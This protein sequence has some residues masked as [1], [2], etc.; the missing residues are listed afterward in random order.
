MPFFALRIAALLLGA[1]F[2][3]PA[4]GPWYHDAHNGIHETLDVALEDICDRLFLAPTH[5]LRKHQA[6]ALARHTLLAERAALNTAMAADDR[7]ADQLPYPTIADATHPRSITVRL[8]PA[9]PRQAWAQLLTRTRHRL[10][11][12]QRRRIHN[13]IALH[14]R[15]ATTAIP[16]S[17]MSA[18]TRAVDALE[19]AGRPWPLAPEIPAK[20]PLP[21]AEAMRTLTDRLHA[22]GP[23]ADLAGCTLAVEHLRRHAFDRAEHAL[24]LVA[25]L[26]PREGSRDELAYLRAC[27]PLR[28]RLRAGHTGQDAAI[29]DGFANYLADHPDGAWRA[30]ALGWQAFLHHRAYRRSGNTQPAELDAAIA[31]YQRIVQAPDLHDLYIRGVESLRICYRDLRSTAQPERLL[32]D[33]RQASLYIYHALT[34]RVY[35]ALDGR[36]RQQC[37]ALAEDSLLTLGADLPADIALTLARAY[38]LI[39]RDAT[40]HE[41][42]TIALT[43]RDD[44]LAHYII[45]RV[46]AD[47]DQRDAAWHALALSWLAHPDAP[48]THELALRVGEAC[49]RAGE[50]SRALLC[51]AHVRSWPD[52]AILSDGEMPL[53]VL[54]HTVDALHQRP[55]ADRYAPT[56]DAELLA[57]LRQRL[58]VRMV[59]HGH[60]AAAR[61]YLDEQTAALLDELMRLEQA[62]G[63]AAPDQRPARLYQLAAFWYHRGY[64]LIYNDRAWHQWAFR[65][66]TEHSGWVTGPWG[67]N[68]DNQRTRPEL[69]RARVAEIEAMTARLRALDLFNTI[70]REHPDSPEAPKALYSSGSCWY[71]LSNPRPMSHCPY[72][73]RR[74]QD[75][76]FMRRGHE[77]MRTL[78][79]RYP[80]HPL[81]DSSWVR[82]MEE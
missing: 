41:L 29:R 80:E 71:W 81:A 27:L 49:E 6:T 43:T 59:R 51:Y 75:E 11:Y 31:I 36:S 3:A 45:G 54:Q 48:L 37:L 38:L 56:I 2:A 77:R 72:W 70:V 57:Y 65:Q 47:A 66:H 20:D 10:D 15:A 64:D 14:A 34:D 82:S 67:D 18:Y 24:D 7:A 28:R 42:A 1:L 79:N 9:P 26:P 32:A 25:A 35:A 4:C 60:R 73:R 69:W 22:G 58:G 52:L 39:D 74:G 8:P 44:P 5:R 19:I 78:R 40:A 21:H 16:A 68:S 33:P 30:D 46:A 53:P 13:R 62:L 23:L 63:A 61:P 50:W 55:G 12:H 17:R 76:G